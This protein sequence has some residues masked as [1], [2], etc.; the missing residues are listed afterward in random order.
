MWFTLKKGAEAI[1]IIYANGETTVFAEDAAI[2]AADPFGIRLD[3][4]KNLRSRN[5]QE[6]TYIDAN[7]FLEHVHTLKS[8]QL[9][10]ATFIAKVRAQLQRIKPTGAHL[11]L[12]LNGEH[13]F[14]VGIDSES[15]L[16]M[17]L[18]VKSKL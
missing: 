2:E 12:L 18:H 6:N 7:D 15:D 3:L 5:K 11:R 16:S 9:F 13:A 17:W 10:D 1:S 14:D 8:V 4:N